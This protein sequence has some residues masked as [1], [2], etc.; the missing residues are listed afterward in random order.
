MTIAEA[1]K[2]SMGF[3]V[4]DAKIEKACIDRGLTSTD[5]YTGIIRAV[6][7]AKADLLIASVT[8]PNISEGGFTISLNERK[9]I[10]AIANKIYSNYG[11]PVVSLTPIV[12]DKSYIW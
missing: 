1:L 9:E 12:Q 5:E 10:V 11:E 6:E 2:S 3:P 7:L 8:M 4:N